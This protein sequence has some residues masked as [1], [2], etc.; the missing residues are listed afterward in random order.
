[1]STPSPRRL[2]GVSRGRLRIYLGAAPGVGKTYAMLDE[3]RRRQARGTDVVIAYADTR[4]RPNT[5]SMLRGLELIPRRTEVVDGTEAEE[6]DLAAVLA[7]RPAVAVVDD[8]AHRNPPGSR[9]RHRHEDVEDLL[10]HGVDVL[11]TVGIESLES[12]QDV[13]ERVIGARP[14]H[15]VPDGIVRGADQVE[16]VDMSPEALRRR[17][18]HGNVVPAPEVDAALDRHFRAD[19]LA[20][21]RELALLWVADQVDERLHEHEV[22]SQ[23]QAR[24]RVVV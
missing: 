2:H 17:V 1:M 8:L 12:L 4:G 20:A 14:A 21:L 22:P 11:A 15:V 9:H 18:V 16:L 6:L 5:A 19:T 3:A 23:W 24:E 13:V 10:A 7:R